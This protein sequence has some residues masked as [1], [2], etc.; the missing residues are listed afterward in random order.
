MVRLAIRWL[1]DTTIVFPCLPSPVTGGAEPGKRPIPKHPIWP[2]RERLQPV[3]GR[4]AHDAHF[5]MVCRFALV[6]VRPVANLVSSE[7]PQPSTVL[8]TL[9]LSLHLFIYY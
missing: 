9:N 1:P 7:L 5:R 6:G 4:V 8:D 2:L 3:V